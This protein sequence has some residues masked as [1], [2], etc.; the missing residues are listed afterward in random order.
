MKGVSKL[1]CVFYAQSTSAVILGRT[2]TNGSVHVLTS[3]LFSKISIL[4]PRVWGQKHQLKRFRGKK[5]VSLD[6][7]GSCQRVLSQLKCQNNMLFVLGEGGGAG[8][9]REW[10]GHYVS[11]LSGFSGIHRHLTKFYLQSQDVSLSYVCHNYNNDHRNEIM[12]KG[13]SNKVSV[14]VPPTTKNNKKCV[15]VFTVVLFQPWLCV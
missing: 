13:Q 7:G 2:Y 10:G 11:R 8:R 5:C 3:F 1:V 14:R 4:Y 12:R 15:A 6:L 9:G